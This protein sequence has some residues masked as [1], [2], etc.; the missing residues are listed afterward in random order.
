MVEMRVSLRFLMS[1]IYLHIPF[2]KQACHYCDFHFSTNISLKGALVQ[3]MADEISL[4]GDYLQGERVDTIY[5]GGGTPSLLHADELQLLLGKLY[6][7]HEVA[8]DAEVTLEANPDDLT[9]A[10]LAEFKLL[11][12]NRLSIGI[13][14]FDDAVLRYLNRAH[15][16]RSAI[17]SVNLARNAGFD[18]LTIDLIYAIP[19][20]SLEGWL[21]NI[22]RAIA[23]GPP[24]ISAY[25]LT[26]EEKTVFGNWLSRGKLKAV[27]EDLAAT[28]LEALMTKLSG[29]G[30][31][32]Y[33]ISNFAFPGRESRHNSSYWQ[34]VPYLGIGP[35]AHSYDRTSRLANIAN[36][37]HYVRALQQKQLPA[38]KEVLSRR[39]RINEYILTSLRTAVGCSLSALRTEFDHDVLKRHA[40]YL[41]ELERHG[42]LSVQDQHL[43]LTPAGRLMADRIAS[44][45]FL[46]D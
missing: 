6:Q 41:A 28:Q 35:G 16:A 23:L 8:P 20:L 15:D 12:I 34:G 33:E 45:L 10:K 44:D 27:S 37:H 4:R 14:S 21:A 39:D 18:N 2:C 17:A 3:A 25:T 40:K 22:D 1:G 46:P 9:A 5:F 38:E 36:N 31:N 42:L 19:G 26:I 24:H 43:R 13:Q 7:H 11:G 29:A 30:Y 32:Q